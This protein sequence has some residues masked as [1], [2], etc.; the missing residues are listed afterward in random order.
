MVGNVLRDLAQSSSV[1][2]LTAIFRITRLFVFADFVVAVGQK[3]AP[4][5]AVLL[6]TGFVI[7]DAFLEVHGAVLGQ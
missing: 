3:E 1:M 2:R 6:M 5:H 7:V 4:V